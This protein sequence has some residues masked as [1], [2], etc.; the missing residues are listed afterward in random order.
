MCVY[1]LFALMRD[2]EEYQRLIGVHQ[3]SG[4]AGYGNAGTTYVKI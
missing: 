2:A 1:S 3:Q 4:S